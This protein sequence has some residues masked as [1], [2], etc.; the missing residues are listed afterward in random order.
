MSSKTTGVS[1]VA[2]GPSKPYE[3]TDCPQCDGLGT[4]A[5]WLE[6]QPNESIT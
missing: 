1:L 3:Y 4:L 2:S 5:V 6:N